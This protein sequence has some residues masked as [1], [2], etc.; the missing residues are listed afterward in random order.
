MKTGNNKQKNNQY[1]KAFL[2]TDD[3]HSIVKHY[4]KQNNIKINMWVDNILKNYLNNNK[5]KNAD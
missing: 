4:C 3:T 1:Q 2:V 5:I